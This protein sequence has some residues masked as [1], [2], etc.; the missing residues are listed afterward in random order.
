MHKTKEQYTSI[1]SHTDRA[2]ETKMIE[3]H[4]RRDI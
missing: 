2:G 3:R 4:V 1:L